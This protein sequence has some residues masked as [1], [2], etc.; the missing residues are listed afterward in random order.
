MA[1]TTGGYP[2]TE[3]HQ[4]PH[5][6]EHHPDTRVIGPPLC[7]CVAGLAAA[8]MAI[9]MVTVVDPPGREV[10]VPR[11]ADAQYCGTTGW[12]DHSPRTPGP[13]PSTAAPAPSVS[14]TSP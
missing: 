2:V 7:W 11:P 3:P 14:L 6:A 5:C 10:R 4:C 12:A 9:L 8:L 13:P 1:D